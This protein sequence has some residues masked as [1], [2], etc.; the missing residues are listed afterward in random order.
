MVIP[1]FSIFILQFVI[2]SITL[3]AVHTNYDAYET[4]NAYKDL[5]TTLQNID[6]AVLILDTIAENTSDY[7]LQMVANDMS[8]SIQNSISQGDLLKE[9][10]WAVF[11]DFAEF[12]IEY[13]VTK[14]IGS[15]WNIPL[16]SAIV[17]GYTLGTVA[18]GYISPVA[19]R[20][21]YAIRVCV[22][23]I[24]SKILADSASTVTRGSNIQYHLTLGHH[25]GVLKIKSTSGQQMKTI[26]LHAATSRIFA[27]NQL[28]DLLNADDGNWVQTNV[29]QTINW[30]VGL[31]S[32]DEY[33]TKASDIIDQCEMSI[34]A[35]NGILYKYNR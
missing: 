11:G 30:L 23:T 31:F 26:Y 15:I 3:N 29:N 16:A 9:S 22:S 18:G 35:M 4:I 5:A 1:I 28:I 33:T 21:E 32:G 17:A 24:V 20:S 14:L 25:I 19:H 10:A 7:T 13:G 8:A 2:D 6:D 27:E 12:G 34:S